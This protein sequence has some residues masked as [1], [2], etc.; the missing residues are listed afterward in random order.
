LGQTG[1]TVSSLTG[2]PVPVTLRSALLGLAMATALGGPLTPALQAADLTQAAAPAPGSSPGAAPANAAAVA[3]T[4]Q[5]AQRVLEALRTGDANARFALFSDALKRTSS[6]TMVANTMK[7]QPKVLS[8][9]I[10][11]VLPGLSHSMVEATLNTT[12]G[13]HDVLLVL[14]PEGLLAGFQYD[15]ADKLSTDV[16]ERFV[17]ALLNG[18]YV[19]AR[20]YLSLSLQDDL[21][22][23]ALQNKWQRLQ[24]VTG[25]AIK[26][27]HLLLA[28][29]A[30]DQK[31]VIASMDFQRLTD[32]L[33]VILNDKNEI[34]GVDFPNEPVKPA[35]A[36]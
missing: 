34:T 31:L 28:D 27:R 4:T 7:T 18:Q 2:L 32:S 25:N 15:N 35:A 29:S 14:N 20:S 22:P 33:F 16:V 1:R 23:S 12:A 36:R 26:L 19:S 21:T 3:K 13:A 17:T 5:A 6:P 11:R 30:P 9:R 10:L 8:Y 24:R